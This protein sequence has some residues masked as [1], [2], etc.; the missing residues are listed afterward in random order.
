VTTDKDFSGW[1]FVDL[2]AGL[3]GFHE[4][5]S[6]LGMEC[7]FASEINDQLQDLYEKN[8]GIRPFGDIRAANEKSDIPSHDVLCAGF[9]C[10]P[11]S[12][13][14][15]KK[16]AKCPSSGK[17]I[18][19][20]VRIAKHHKPKYVFLENVPN[21]LTI[22]DGK[23]W[24]YI[25]RA[26]REAGYSI[27]YRVYSPV[28]FGIPQK[29]KRVFVIASRDEASINWPALDGPVPSK[30]NLLDYFEPNLRKA[31]DRQL[32]PAKKEIL[33][34]WETLI[35]GLDD[36]SH[37]AIVSPEFGATYP[38]TG[39]EGKS[40]SEIK[41]YKGAWGQSL[42]SCTSW[43]DVFDLLPH[44]VKR[45]TT[46]PAKWLQGSVEYSRQ[47][48][49]NHASFLDSF[50]HLLADV[51]RSWQKIQWQG[52]RANRK[53][54][55]HLIQFRASGIRVIKPQSAPSLIAMTTT[56]IPIIGQT[57]KYIDAWQAASLQGLENLANLPESTSG[58][59]KALGN[60]VNAKI[61]HEVA[62]AAF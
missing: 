9:P 46:Q 53:M 54:A 50:K 4:A 37:H 59:F 18:D 11:F 27:D 26:F 62:L 36:L 30:N 10:Q 3:G 60:A 61:V 15:R 41:Q 33:G 40:L 24:A 48:Y 44:Y 19:D 20:V 32:E 47:L 31:E 35:A 45:E 23:F 22:D 39:F 55:S 17:L 6:K 1:K 51:P 12:L 13:A 5:L 29:R 28:D 8:H 43:D 34:V 7:V 49:S 21:I 38:L 16:G 2:F 57:G 52:D 25:T 42:S 56:Q 14:G 58:A